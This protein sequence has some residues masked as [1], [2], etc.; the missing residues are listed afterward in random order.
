VIVDDAKCA[1]F[2]LDTKRVESIARRLS[3]AAKEARSMG[4]VVFGGSGKGTLRISGKGV[5]G[6]VADLDGIFD[7][8]DGGDDY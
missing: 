5:S 3:K 7:G 8:G 6:E 1:E 4:L 2:G